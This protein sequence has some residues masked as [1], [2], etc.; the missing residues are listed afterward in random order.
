MLFAATYPERVSALAICSSFAKGSPDP[1]HPGA[2]SG[3]AVELAR[4][5]TRHWGE[6]RSMRLFTGSTAGGRWHERMYGMFERASASPGMARAAFE[7]TLEVDVTDEASVANLFAE[8]A[9]LCGRLDILINNAGINIRKPPHDLTLAEWRHVLDTN[10]KG[11]F[12]C[13][14]AAGR[15]MVPRGR[16]TIVNVASAAALASSSREAPATGSAVRSATMV[17]KFSR[18]S[19]RPWEI[20]GWYGVYAVYQLGSSSTLRRITAGV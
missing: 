19:R 20:S 17:W 11:A 9:A 1:E 12:F 3:D 10:L 6:G 2:L 4:D 14:Q 18:A 13:A 5:A 7:S 16:G 15:V 8:A